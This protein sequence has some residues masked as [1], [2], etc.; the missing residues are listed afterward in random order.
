MNQRKECEEAA[1]SLRAEHEHLASVV[2]GVHKRLRREYRAS[3]Q[4]HEAVWQQHSQDQASLKLY[5]EAMFRLATE[6]WTVY[7][8]TRID[9]CRK[10]AREYFLQDGLR[11]AL[12]KDLKRAKH[13]KQAEM[14]SSSKVSDL[15]KS[16]QKFV[17]TSPTDVDVCD[18]EFDTERSKS[19]SDACPV[20]TVPFTCKIRLLDVG[21]CYNPF[22]GSEDF[23]A[24]GLDLSPAVPTVIQCDFLQLVSS[25]LPPPSD[26]LTFDL[27]T[28]S[29]PL[30]RLP[31]CSFH[32]VVFSLLLEYLPSPLQRWRCCV[33]AHGLL[34][35]NGL[36]LVITP[37]SHSQHR[38][39]PMM[40]SWKM[41]LESL[42]F[43]RWKYEKKDHIHCMAFRK[44]ISKPSLMTRSL[45][46]G[47]DGTNIQPA[48]MLYI[49]QDFNDACYDD[50]LDKTQ[51][52]NEDEDEDDSSNFLSAACELPMYNDDDNY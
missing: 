11:I 5:A 29:S 13:K 49:P 15:S 24:V 52:N 17:Q 40:K 50:V 26:P 32:V 25:S 23:D 36:L 39:A 22:L 12:E 3:S 47:T 43:M 8:E 35:I 48:E 4:Q 10:V 46:P 41:A 38:N 51:K 21:S 20:V 14:L 7:P 9:W 18:E 44:V 31:A 42:G 16:T 37:D 2:K 6:H 45:D 33:T 34:A 27:N 30:Q 28:L 19:R 1:K